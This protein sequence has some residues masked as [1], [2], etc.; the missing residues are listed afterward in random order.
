MALKH[1]A[2]LRKSHWE[3]SERLRNIYAARWWGCPSISYFD[4][5]PREE[6]INIIAAYEADWRM[7]AVNSYEMAEEAA[8]KAKQKTKKA[9]R[10][11]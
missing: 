8:H 3:Y 10:G 1:P 5:L 9:P 2:L 7:N 11:R 4:Q 6:K